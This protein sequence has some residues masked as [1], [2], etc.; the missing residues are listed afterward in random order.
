MK[1]FLLLIISIAL[2]ITNYSQSIKIDLKNKRLLNK[3]LSFVSESN[4]T[5][6]IF[7]DSAYVGKMIYDGQVDSLSVYANNIRISLEFVFPA[8]LLEWNQ[9][10]SSIIDSEIKKQ[11]LIKLE[12][13]RDFSKNRNKN[14][15]FYKNVQS[16]LNNNHQVNSNGKIITTVEYE[17]AV[18]AEKVVELENRMK[19]QSQLS[20]STWDIYS[21]PLNEVK[22]NSTI[23]LT[24]DDYLK[25]SS[26][27]MRKSAKTRTVAKIVTI[28]GAVVIVLVPTFIVIGA[29]VSSSS[30]I[31]D[32]VSDSQLE[33]SAYYLEKSS[34]SFE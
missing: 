30:I 4:Y 10:I 31:F 11:Y 16:L 34:N 18:A 19:Y 25:I 29:V 8:D 6:S 28:A 5:T 14:P 17:N 23:E 7:I 32:F 9:Q 22:S 3:E 2:S 13:D 33:K 27:F 1:R 24:K 26:H 15:N 21:Q 12:S 20:G